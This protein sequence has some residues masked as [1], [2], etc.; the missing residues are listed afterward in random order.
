MIGDALIQKWRDEV[1]N[2]YNKVTNGLIL[3]D[4]IALAS[5][6]SYEATIRAVSTG[7]QLWI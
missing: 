1:E 5:G 7:L 4:S 6:K 3:N 2:Y